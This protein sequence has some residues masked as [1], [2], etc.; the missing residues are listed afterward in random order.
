MTKMLLEVKA[1]KNPSVW[2]RE[3]VFQGS[4]PV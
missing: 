3:I 2:Q 4:S 1:D